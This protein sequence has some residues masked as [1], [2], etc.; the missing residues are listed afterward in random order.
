MI[1]AD[2]S[3]AGKL[4]AGH[5]LDYQDRS[6]VVLGLPRGGVEVAAEVALALGAPLDVIVARKL[7][8]PGNPELAIGAVTARGTRVLNDALLRQVLLPPGFLGQETE[9]QRRV[10]EEREQRLR[11][12]RPAISLEGRNVILV[13][14]GI[15]TGMTALAA[16]HDLWERH[17]RAVVLA[18]PVGPRR[19]LERLQP[20]VDAVVSL[21][22]PDDFLAIGQFYEDFSQVL[23]E[24]VTELLAANRLAV[25]PGI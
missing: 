5:L 16:I 22:T 6:P 23:D 1:F 25:G 21:E 4:L 18:T 2:R 17:P 19:T 11:A 20:E 13:D 10:A 14:D 7:G 8:F 15:A 12:A 24:R 9:S 3:Q